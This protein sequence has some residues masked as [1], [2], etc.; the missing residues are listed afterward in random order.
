[1]LHNNNIITVLLYSFFL[2]AGSG[3][4]LD[5]TTFQEE[6]TGIRTF[7]L[8]D[9]S[10]PTMMTIWTLVLT[11][12]LLLTVAH[13]RICQPTTI[14]AV[15]QVLRGGSKVATEAGPLKVFIQTIKEARRHLVAAAVARSVSI[16][17]M[18]PVDTIKVG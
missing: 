1:M 15:P 14:T 2:V 11:V 13:G 10:S 4:A 16:F 8:I 12:A 9:Y 17:A 6:D 18:Y 7:L 5:P 3:I